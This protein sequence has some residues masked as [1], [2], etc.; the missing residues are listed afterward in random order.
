MRYRE[1]TGFLAAIGI[2]TAAGF[3]SASSPECFRNIEKDACKVI[4]QPDP[5]TGLCFITTPLGL[6]AT[7]QDAVQAQTGFDEVDP[8]GEEEWCRYDPGV[9]DENG[10]CLYNGGAPLFRSVFCN[11]AKGNDDCGTPAGP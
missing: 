2:A 4:P 5:S 6:S 3:V 10:N 1:C 11:R 7:C 8:I 9:L